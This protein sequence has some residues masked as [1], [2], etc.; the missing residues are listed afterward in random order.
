MRKG[1]VAI[2]ILFML[3]GLS[4]CQRED[5]HQKFIEGVPV[6]PQGT[7]ISARGVQQYFLLMR[8]SL[9]RMVQL[10]NRLTL[11]GTS[12]TD[13]TGPDGNQAYSFPINETRYGSATVTLKF[14]DTNGA[15]IDPISNPVSTS[16]VKSVSFTMTGNSDLF[17]FL[18]NDGLLTLDSAGIL[19][20]NKLASGSLSLT[21]QGYTMTFTMPATGVQA[22]YQGPFEGAV[23]GM[24]TGPTEAF[25][26]NLQF[27][28]DHNLDG[29]L[30]WEGKT[31]GI[32]FS[33]N[34]TGYLVSD[35]EKILLE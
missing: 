15:V 17:A 1:W 22:N 30:A 32:R 29:T 5:V 7:V 16:S 11:T 21:G 20:P 18:A 3:C 19:S 13:L 28:A 24:G 33:N 31:G 6:N 14:L 25:T 2:G 9:S 35:N 23:T 27:S 8:D 26:A 4:S 34:G 10:M 12:F